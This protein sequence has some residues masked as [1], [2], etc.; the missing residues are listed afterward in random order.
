MAV[1]GIRVEGNIGGE[2]VFGYLLLLT[3]GDLGVD[4]VIRVIRVLAIGVLRGG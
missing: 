3:V 4:F 2:G 1:G